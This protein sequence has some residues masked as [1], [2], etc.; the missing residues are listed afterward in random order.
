MLSER[1]KRI[2][3]EL[4]ST[5]PTISI[6]RAKLVT[7]F[8]KQPS[9]ESAVLR[10]ANLFAY[11]LDNMTIY[12]GKD[13]LLAGNHSSRFRSVPVFPE[14]GARWILDEI[15][16]F[17]TRQTDP[18]YFIGDEKS[19]LIQ[20]LEQWDGISL[21]EIVN[22]EISDEVMDAAANGLLSVG[23]RNTSTG[24]II[25]DYDTLLKVGFNGIIA[26]AEEKIAEAKLGME[27]VDD[28]KKIDFWKAI[29]ITSKAFI[30][31]GERYSLLAAQEAESCKDETRKKELLM[32]SEICKRIPANPPASFYEAVQFVWFVHLCVQIESNGH[33]ISYGRFDQYMYPF[34]KKDVEEGILTE[35]QAAELLESLWLKTTEI[36]KIRDAFDSQAFASYPMWQNLT[37]GG[38]TIYGKD[39][40]NELTN[41]ILDVTDEV[42]T[43]QPSISFRY[44][45]HIDQATF[46]RALRITQ[47]GIAMPAF[48]N[49]E[50]VIP[51][52]LEQ[53]A[54][55]KEARNWAVDGCVEPYIPGKT[56]GRPVV[57]YI[58]AVKLVEMT[59]NN[60]F[61]PVSKRQM[62]PQ[63]GNMDEAAS[64]DEFMDAYEKQMHYFN[65]MMIEN[66]N[67]V[68]AIHAQ[69]QPTVFAA[70]LVDSCIEKGKTLQEGG[71]KYNFSGTFV[72]APANAADSLAAIDEIVFKKKQMT[73]R[74]LRE[75]LVE[76]FEGKEDVRQM[77]LNRVPKFG[78][79]D[80]MVD[81][82][83][84]K[85]MDL[86]VTDTDQ[87]Q[88]PRGGRYVVSVLSQSFNVL[89]GKSVGATP[90]GRKAFT[91]LA[92]NASPVASRDVNGPT[93]AVRSVS[94]M[95]QFLAL[96]GTLLNQKF[97]PVVVK[98]EEGLKILEALVRGYF[99][100]MGQHIQINVVDKETLYDAQKHPE[101]YPNLMVRVAGYSAYFIDLDSEV[102]QNIIDRTEQIG[103]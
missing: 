55:I 4:R 75:V 101:K 100:E 84:H 99:A 57:G 49:D 103:L 31:F 62:G 7:D 9:I 51:I 34:Y 61:D 1:I 28:R 89:Q 22:E 38:Q 18:L 5:K 37:I 17:E 20:I 8:Y 95:D 58:N 83:A 102:Q 50:L 35:A 29:I 90:D 71:A 14:I 19:E 92:D 77:L 10:K 44:H 43:I 40:C 24:Q 80:D 12:I 82:Y 59:L 13:E 42:E 52:M 47:K 93:A 16:T 78:N 87:Y 21:N 79:D 68:T 76:D 91:P 81:E 96:T 27:T 53:G 11:L 30:R 73:M 67:T 45:R 98:G 56:D 65:S 88:D 63:T 46:E 3:A 36:I 70:S 64:M 54:T 69:I 6:E 86:I 72:T 41:L 32:I 74:E 97:D 85:I 2:R 60:G 15:E 66:Y 26:Q 48:Y 23:S 39:A 25:P 33:G 94:K